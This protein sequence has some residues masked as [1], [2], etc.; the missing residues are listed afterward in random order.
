MDTPQPREGTKDDRATRPHGAPSALRKASH[1]PGRQCG[2]RRR[3]RR[4]DDDGV[5]AGRQAAPALEQKLV[6][7]VGAAYDRLGDSVD[8]D[9]DTAVVGAPS[10]DRG[11]GAVYEFTRTGDTWTQTAK[12]TASDGATDGRLGN[13]VAIDGGTI[14]AGAPYD[15]VGANPDQ[16]SA[17]VFFAPVDATA[18]TVTIDQAAGQVDPASAAHSRALAVA[19]GERSLSASSCLVP[20][21][22]TRAPASSTP[23]RP[24]PGQPCSMRASTWPRS[25][26]CTACCAPKRRGARVPGPGH[27]SAPDDP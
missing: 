15:D 8:I 20:A 11:K 26:P 12:L 13:S 25:P 18:P 24:R 6:A 7:S 1:V 19:A 27:T 4:V 9:G 17:S 22:W 14:V 23:P 16:G 5:G 2:D 3:A 10:V 21:R